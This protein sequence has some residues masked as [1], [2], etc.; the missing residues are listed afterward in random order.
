MLLILGLALPTA[1]SRERAVEAPPGPAV[2]WSHNLE[3]AQAEAQKTGGRLLLSFEAYWCPWSRL[4]RESLYTHASVVESLRSFRCVA[5]S[6]D[7]DSAL[8]RTHGVTVYPTV[9]VTDAYGTETARLTGYRSPEEF[10]RSLSSAGQSDQAL[11]EMFRLE[12]GRADDAG[13]L[14]H[15]GDLLRDMGTPDAAL[16]RYG[17]AAEAAR[18]KRQDLYEEATYAMAECTMLAGQY[19]S[20]A[21]RFRD[22]LADNPGGNRCEEAMVLAALCHKLA[23]ED[24]RAGEMLE[25]YLS[26]YPRGAY[27]QQVRRQV[28]QAGTGGSRGR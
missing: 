18:G 3:E 24:A 23:R 8:C 12:Q 16:I 27:A 9:I 25:A 22:F 10:L 21:Q 17:R 13:F 15:F 20:A 5:L 1:C 2:A 28:H 14:L 26:A 7:Q 6:D 11:A 4:M 19:R